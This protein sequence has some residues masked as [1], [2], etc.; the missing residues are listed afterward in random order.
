MSATLESA[1][2]SSSRYNRAAVLRSAAIQIGVLLVV[3]TGAAWYEAFHLNSLVDP[4]IWWHLRTGTWILQN[5]AVP[6]SG[7]FS[8]MSSLP[9][10]NCNWAFDV[11]VAGANRVFGLSGL[12]FLSILLQV[13]IA[14]ALL[15]LARFG[16]INFWAA[17]SLSV[18]GQYCIAGRGLQ[19]SL[20]SIVFFAV[21]LAFLFKTR[22]S[23]RLRFFVWMPVIF[24]I[25]ANVDRLFV[26][27]LAALALF[28]AANF[29]EY[30]S[31][32]YALKWFEPRQSL[33]SFR[34]G[35]GSVAC[36][37]ATLLSPYTWHIYKPI[38]LGATSEAD[39][40][41]PELH[42]MRFREPRDFILMLLVMS[43]FVAL[44]LRRS[45]DPFRLSLLILS[46]VISF[47]LQRDSWLVVLVAVGIIAGTL[48][49][50]ESAE[51]YVEWTF[52]KAVTAALV[53]VV[54]VAAMVRMFT[55]HGSVEERV[56]TTFPAHGAEYIAQ[57]HL[58]PALFNSYQWGGFLTWYL[59]NYPVVIDGRFD[60][61]GDANVVA[62][63][64]LMSGE[65]PLE[66][67]PT[68]ARAQTFVLESH[69]PMAEALESL[70]AF[71]VVY[72]DDVAAV[73]V[74]R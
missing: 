26:Y 21:T 59:P 10:V 62:H 64:K 63:F 27:G 74:R 25:W 43:A 58:P 23:G 56:A 52:R 18:L 39:R 70:P 30:V 34:V 22:D 69:S 9:W 61:Y 46:A 45:R 13:A 71:R 32:R 41:F 66:S 50:Q 73:L 31:E 54:L 51:V 16:R 11:V 38:W 68:F 72:R 4:D 2:R 65:I 17:V 29:I 47:R 55:R 1:P 35:P 57:N 3:L 60:L 14:A 36:F 5:H 67:N 24:A 44:G 6:R 15:F 20:L 12:P 28:C 33:D 49:R 53:V 37:L 7:I 8:Q 42:S 48:R 19:P 40:Y